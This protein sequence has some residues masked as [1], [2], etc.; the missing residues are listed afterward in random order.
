[1]EDKSLK[2]GVYGF[3]TIDD[4]NGMLGAAGPGK[5]AVVI[6]GGLLGLEAARGLLTHGCD[7]TVV[8]LG[9]HLMEQQVDPTGGAML[10]TAMEKMGV[11]VL[12]ATSTTAGAG[13]G[14]RSRG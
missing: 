8:H 6:G 9:A 13:R 11:K 7:V 10:K 3:R 5:K 4:T 1:M 2:P 14:A 12:L